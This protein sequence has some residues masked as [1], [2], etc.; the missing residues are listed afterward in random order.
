MIKRFKLRPDT[1]FK[2]DSEEVVKRLTLKATDFLQLTLLDLKLS[3]LSLYQ[4]TNQGQ[5]AILS[6]RIEDSESLSSDF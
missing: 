2:V 6:A 4:V 3:K 5:L 1:G